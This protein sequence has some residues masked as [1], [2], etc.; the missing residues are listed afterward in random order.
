MVRFLGKMKIYNFSSKRKDFAKAETL[1]VSIPKSGRTWLRYL[2]ASYFTKLEGVPF[3]FTAESTSVSFPYFTHDL[4]EHKTTNHPWDKL[5]GKH[6]IPEPIRSDK[7]KILLSRDLRDVSVSMFFQLVKREQLF[8]GEM[9]E[10]LRDKIFGIE[11]IVNII[12]EWN[13]SWSG[14]PNFMTWSYEEAKEDPEKA[15]G[16]VVKFLDKR[17]LNVGVLREA[18]AESDFSKMKKAEANNA[19]QNKALTPGDV[20]DAES[21][22]V[23]RGKVHGFTDYLSSQDVEFIEQACQNLPQE[24]RPL[25][26]QN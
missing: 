23:R 25:F 17:P 11:A 13:H 22:K 9:S 19:V 12:N 1:I 5:R 21:F 26:I 8:E 6:L 14:R 20:K 24:W 7:P 15:F 3:H 18:I 10:M 16:E 2:L 4:W